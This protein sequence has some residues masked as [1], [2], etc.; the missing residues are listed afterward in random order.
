MTQ[1]TRKLLGLL[2][3]LALLVAYVWLASEIYFRFLTGAA[4][5]LLLGYFAFA[6]FFWAVPV[7]FVIW[8]M[9]RPDSSRSNLAE[10][11]EDGPGREHVD[12]APRLEQ[13]VERNARQ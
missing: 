4:T 12:I 3:M 8:W 9:E 10:L 6:G 5:Q 1:G 7:A 11:G 2:A 13:P